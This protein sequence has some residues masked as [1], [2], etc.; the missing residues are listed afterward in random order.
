MAIA[1]LHCGIPWICNCNSIPVCLPQKWL[2]GLP[3]LS[4]AS[5]FWEIDVG[6][7]LTF[8]PLSPSVST[9]PTHIKPVKLLPYAD[10]CSQLYVRIK[11][12]LFYSSISVYSPSASSCHL[13]LVF[14]LLNF[15]VNI[16]PIFMHYFICI[17]LIFGTNLLFF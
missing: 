11:E 7:H 4:W 8:F 2:C 1:L 16:M 9:L 17:P 3:H 5:Q 15:W 6:L 14:G 10:L 12:G 13:L